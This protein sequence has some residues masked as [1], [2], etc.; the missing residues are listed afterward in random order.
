M[1]AAPFASNSFLMGLLIAMVVAVLPAG[2]HNGSAAIWLWL[3][4]AGSGALVLGP[5][6]L[7]ARA[8][9]AKRRAFIPLVAGLAIASGPVMVLGRVIKT[10]THHRP[11]GAMTYA[12]VAC[13]V[14]LG[15]WVLA[16]RLDQ[17]AQEPGGSLRKRGARWAQ[18]G[19]VGVSLLLALLAMGG[20]GAAL[21]P[22]VIDTAVVLMLATI[23]LWL[24]VD[25]SLRKVPAGVVWPAWALMVGAGVWAS[26]MLGP[27][28]TQASLP[29]SALAALIGH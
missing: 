25:Q 15:S 8:L 17:A 22:V 23:V 28:A 24:G 21:A 1:S 5:S 11:L 14:V 6:L 2:R 19:L 7:G 4:C 18:V 29:L 3:A 9:L 16:W 12:V 27:S 13:L 20:L 26:L 10:A